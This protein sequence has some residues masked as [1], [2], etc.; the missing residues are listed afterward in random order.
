ML[1]GEIALVGIN[2]AIPNGDVA[3]NNIRKYYKSKKSNK[4]RRHPRVIRGA[5]ATNIGVV[6]QGLK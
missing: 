6:A 2:H 4:Y 1:A 3:H 5:K